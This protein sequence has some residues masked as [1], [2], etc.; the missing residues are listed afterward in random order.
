[1]SI[2]EILMLLVSVLGN[3]GPYL[4]A[5]EKAL[6]TGGWAGLVAYLESL[7]NLNPTGI[8]ARE[9]QDLIDRLK[10]RIATVITSP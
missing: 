6:V 10:A 9:L 4:L 8:K 1:M 5:A 7:L 2:F 3:V